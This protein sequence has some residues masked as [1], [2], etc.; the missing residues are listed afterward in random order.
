LKRIAIAVAM[1]WLAS[2]AVA[3]HAAAETS[4]SAS[5]Y[6][7]FLPDYEDY[8]QPTVAVDHAALHF[9][10]RYNYEDLETG[11]AWAGYAFSGGETWS[12][13]LTPMLGGV[14]GNSNGFAPG[15]RAELGYWKLELYSEGEYFVD[16]SGGSE[17]FF[18]SWSELGLSLVEWFRGGV[19]AQRTHNYQ[20]ER[21]LSGGVLVG[22]SNELASVTGYV[23]DLTAHEPTV[24]VALALTIDR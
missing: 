11:S 8:V 7:Y 1:V 24:V 9:E 13:Q 10:A 20:T 19:V 14:F 2:V 4:I 3:R 12:W 22:F 23:F 17:H 5:V 18:Y 21:E 6:T 16:L 15:Y